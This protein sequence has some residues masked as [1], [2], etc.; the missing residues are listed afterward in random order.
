[1]DIEITEE[2]VNSIYAMGDYFT[3][4]VNDKMYE[5]TSII[6]ATGVNF[7]KPFKGKKSF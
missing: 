6:L 3:L 1:M 5:A 4:M 7:G 2:K